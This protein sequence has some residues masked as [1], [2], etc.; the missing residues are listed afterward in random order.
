M[1][2]AKRPDSETLPLLAPRDL[3]VASLVTAVGLSLNGLAFALLLGAFESITPREAIA[4]AAI[5]N[6]A[7]AAGIAAVPFPSGIGVR[8]T[9]LFSLLATLVPVEVAVASGLLMRAMSVS[10]DLAFGILG[11]ATIGMRATRGDRPLARRQLSTV[12]EIE[13]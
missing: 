8:E 10:L 7:G 4:A 11:V 3:I 6:L 9:I 1:K 5:F 13:T 2:L 12:T